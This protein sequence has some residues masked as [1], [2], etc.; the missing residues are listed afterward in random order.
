MRHR[1]RRRL[2]M[3]CWGCGR[4]WRKKGRAFCDFFR[5]PFQYDKEDLLLRKEELQE[6]IQNINRKLKELEQHEKPEDLE[7]GGHS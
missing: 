7:F 1:R 3:N 5:L 4:F 2:R 6:R